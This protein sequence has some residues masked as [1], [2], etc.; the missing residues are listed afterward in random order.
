MPPLTDSARVT[1]LLFAQY[2][3][4]VGR[5]RVEISL[6]AGATVAD[7]LSRFRSEVAGA[8]ALP[9]R[10]MCAVNH[11]HVLPGHHLRDGDEVAILPPL[12]G[13]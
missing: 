6:A 7:L 3:D 1:I 11:S 2:A 10:P 12:A 13:G 5:S 9:E 4:A 8:A